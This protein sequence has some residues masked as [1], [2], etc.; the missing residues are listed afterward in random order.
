M[1]YCE[2]VE[3]TESLLVF[4]SKPGF[5]R[6]EA[7]TNTLGNPEK[8]LR[9]IH[10]AGTN[11]KGSVCY[12]TRNILEAAGYRTGLF[13]SPYVSDFRERIQI[14]GHLIEKDLFAAL[15]ERVKKE[16]EKLEEKGIQPTEFEFL[17]ALAFL[18]FR[19]TGV[20]YVVLETGLGGLLDSTNII[21]K[22]VVT[23]VT[24][25]S[26][27]HTNIL[28]DTIEE[29]AFQKA[30]IFKPFVPALSACN[31]P[32][33]ALKVLREEA[34]KRNCPFR[35]CEVK[36]KYVSSSLKGQVIDIE[37]RKVTLP[38]YGD[39]QLVNLA[40][41]LSIIDEL[42]KQGLEISDKAVDEG[43]SETR[44]PGRI[45]VL[46]EKPVVI[47]DGGHN[48]SGVTALKETLHEQGI[49]KPV[50]VTGVMKDKETEKMAGIIKSFAGRIIT[51]TPSVP[52]AM[53]AEDFRK[54]F[55]RAPGEAEVKAIDNPAE[56][57]RQAL[58]S[59]KENETLLVA[60]S[61]YLV[62]EVREKL[63]SMIDSRKK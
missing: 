41:T 43:L 36:E 16:T 32:E 33:G 26:M 59:L 39:H 20:D 46:S 31:Q 15:A 34:L 54:C 57:V 8:D 3:Y 30:G 47:I 28:G 14:D 4:G 37:G 2:A 11:G 22:P 25:L 48:V 40:V 44:I 45:E 38:L 63:I 42:R 27:D 62:G 56:A 24:S 6:I 7:L 60:G 17:T 58:D 29:I 9:I 13:T 50:T 10:V 53:D 21:E 5:Q 52:R 12:E 19:E 18:A 51:V 1:T 55:D 23:A 61:L 49:E 35:I